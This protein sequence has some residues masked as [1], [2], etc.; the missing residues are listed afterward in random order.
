[1]LGSKEHAGQSW[2]EN[3]QKNYV[4][5][6]KLGSSS[7][8]FKNLYGDDLVCEWCIQ[9]VSQNIVIFLCQPCGI[10]VCAHA[11]FQVFF[12]TFA[13]YFISFQKS[14][15][16]NSEIVYTNNWFFEQDFEIGKY[17]WRGY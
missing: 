11:K 16:V 1:L 14:T 13:I 7:S 6:L 8:N 9:W 15:K 4:V 5:Y 17:L 3:I 10:I 2:S 12:I